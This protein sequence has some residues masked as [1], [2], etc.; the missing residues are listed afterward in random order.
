M[1]NKSFNFDA[2]FIYK[3]IRTLDAYNLKIVPYFSKLELS[4]A[5]CDSVARQ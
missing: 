3:I 5:I 2:V 1:F 4:M